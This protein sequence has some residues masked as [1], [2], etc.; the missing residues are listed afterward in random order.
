LT[1]RSCNTSRPTTTNFIAVFTLL[2]CIQNF[3]RN[4]V[5]ERSPNSSQYGGL[6]YGLDD[7]CSFLCRG[8][9]FILFVTAPRPALGPTQPPIQWVP[10]ALTLRVKWPGREADHSPPSNTEVK[11]AW[12]Y[13]SAPPYFMAW[14]LFK[15][16]D[17]FNFTLHIKGN[18]QSE[19]LGIGGKLILERI[20][21]K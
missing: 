5:R 1:T 19:D 3:G 6:G 7:R 15:H 21:E 11:N 18:D 10:E 16:M 9:D 4:T 2:K 14:Y 13:T 20:F 17:N 12:S 8:R